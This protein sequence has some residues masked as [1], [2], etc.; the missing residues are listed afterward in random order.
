MDNDSTMLSCG[1]EHVKEKNKRNGKSNRHRGHAMRFIMKELPEPA[2]PERVSYKPVQTPAVK[3]ISHK[4]EL[5]I[6]LALARF[7]RHLSL[8]AEEREPLCPLTKNYE[9]H[10]AAFGRLTKEEQKEIYPYLA[11]EWRIHIANPA[12]L[13][14]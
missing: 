12:N 7:R 10:A 9:H 6:A 3:A 13:Q 5:A 4:Q 1:M 11:P 14:P 8:P 2:D